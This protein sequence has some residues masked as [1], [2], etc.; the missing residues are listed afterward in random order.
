MN[1]NRQRGELPQ[2]LLNV[3]NKFSIYDG[4]EILYID[5]KYVCR[6]P[7]PKKLSFPIKF[8]KVSEV[9]EWVRR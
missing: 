3:M 9:I 6:W 2:E 1:K 7:Q 5:G 8:D 4:P